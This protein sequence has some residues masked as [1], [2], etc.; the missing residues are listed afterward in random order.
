[1]NVPILDMV[2]GKD[3][4]IAEAV[5]ISGPRKGQI[6]RLNSDNTTEP[7]QTLTPQQWQ[8]LNT[9]LGTMLTSLDELE[10]ELRETNAAMRKGL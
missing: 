3:A 10:T 2:R 9:T 6:V 1:M 4:E 7:E 8:L 5:I